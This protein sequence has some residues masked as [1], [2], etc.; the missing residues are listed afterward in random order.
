M[1]LTLPPLL[2][3]EVMSRFCF[4]VTGKVAEDLR[5]V[6]GATML[7][8]VT[9]LRVATAAEEMTEEAILLLLSFFG[10]I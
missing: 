2:A 3:M 1:Q 5:P 8:C 9:L 6:K 4:F 10:S 7:A